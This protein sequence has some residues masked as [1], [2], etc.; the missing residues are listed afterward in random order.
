MKTFFMDTFDRKKIHVCVWD[1]VSVIKGCVVISHGMAEHVERYND[2]ALFLNDKGYVVVGDDHRGHKHNSAGA[3]GMVE[4]DSFFQT[5]RDMKD[6]VDMSKQKYSQNVVLLGH[7]YGSFLSQRFIELYSQDINGCI[8][9]GT[10]YMISPLIS[11]GKKVAN[12]Q[13]VLFGPDKIAYFINTLS[14]G[15]YN[16]Q[17]KSEG[18]EFAWLSRDKNQ[19]LKYIDDEYCG[20]EMS[21]G[22]Y[23]SFFKGLLATHAKE[24]T[25]VRKDLPILIAVGGDDPVSNKASLAYKLE[26]QY[27]KVNKLNKVEIKVYDGAR[28]EILNETNRDEVYADFLTFIEKCTQGFQTSV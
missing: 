13:N 4:G 10:A 11:F 28:H 6:V 18:L 8:L 1:D 16:K 27:K 19:V 21:L 7:S 3:K 22:F 17:F 14:F 15:S 5:V 25:G 26:D 12:F 20:Y 2:F 9:S 23:K 24:R